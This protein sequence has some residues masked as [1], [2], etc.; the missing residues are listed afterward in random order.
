MEEQGGLHSQKPVSYTHLNQDSTAIEIATKEAEQ[1]IAIFSGQKQNVTDTGLAL[2][3]QSGQVNS[4]KVQYEQVLESIKSTE[5]LEKLHVSLS[6]AY[7]TVRLTRIEFTQKILND[8][9]SECN[10]LYAEIHPK[11]P[12]AIS[13]LEL[14]VGKRASLNQAA[15]FEGHHDVPPQA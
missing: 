2:S 11:E 13:R 14:D 7:N 12:I 8:I 4:I 3:K 10:R 9:A 15:S 6:E 1:L 5:G